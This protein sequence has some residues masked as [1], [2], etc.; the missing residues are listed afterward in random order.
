MSGRMARSRTLCPP[1]C[2]VA[3]LSFLNIILI[4]D[5][6]HLMPASFYI[7]CLLCATQSVYVCVLCYVSEIGFI[8]VE[9]NQDV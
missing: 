6:L 8:L 4:V 1:Y 5:M 3:V 2:D 9:S 7:S